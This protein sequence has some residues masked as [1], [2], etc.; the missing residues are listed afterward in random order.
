M[1]T[2]IEQFLKDNPNSKL[3]D[4]G[5]PDGACPDKIYGNEVFALCDEALPISIELCKEC[6]GQE[7]KKSEV[8]KAE[9]R[10][11]YESMKGACEGC[12]HAINTFNYECQEVAACEL[13]DEMDAYIQGV[14]VCTFREKKLI[15][16][17]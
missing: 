5:L 6:W 14:E 13:G 15:T 3:T 12:T 16:S 11:K 17:V 4:F 7:V 2:L 10:G 8:D 1:K 9:D